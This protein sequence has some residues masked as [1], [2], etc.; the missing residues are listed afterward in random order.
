MQSCALLAEAIYAQLVGRDGQSRAV[1]KNPGCTELS[2][3]LVDALEHESIRCVVT[4]HDLFVWWGEALLHDDFIR[5]TGIAGMKIRM[6]PNAILANLE[7]IGAPDAF[8]WI[9][10]G[11]AAHE[12]DMEDRRQIVEGWLR[13]DHR[14]RYIYG[15]DFTI[16]W[17]M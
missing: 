6:L 9:F 7:A 10:A 16:R 8:P 13:A 17:Y 11:A 5:Q 12:L 4:A 14:L 2:K 1:W 15:T 3:A